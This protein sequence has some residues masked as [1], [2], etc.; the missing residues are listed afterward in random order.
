MFVPSTD[1]QNTTHTHYSSSKIPQQV[2]FGLRAA[3][4]WTYLPFAGAHGSYIS[5]ITVPLTPELEL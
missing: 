3:I 4:L 2:G 1:T 5:G